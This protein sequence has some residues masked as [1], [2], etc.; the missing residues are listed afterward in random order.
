MREVFTTALELVGLAAIVA[1]VGFIFWPAALIAG[2][3]GA[4]F[5]SRG[6]SSRGVSE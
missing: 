1:G 3:V 6:L 2:G 5:I 4:I